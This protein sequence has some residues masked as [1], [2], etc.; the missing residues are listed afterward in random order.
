MALDTE[1]RKRAE[2][3]GDLVTME[4]DTYFKQLLA[5][6][7]AWEQN[8]PEQADELLDRCPPGSEAGNG[9][10]STAVPL[11]IADAPRA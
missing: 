7:E 2:A 6:G 8:R 11:R 10:T 4:D 3:E 9:I 5:A 1:T